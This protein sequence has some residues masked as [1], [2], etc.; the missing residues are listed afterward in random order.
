MTGKKDDA[1]GHDSDSAVSDEL[2]PMR[3]WESG[4]PGTGSY[5]TGPSH[6]D[7]ADF[8]EDEEAEAKEADPK[9]EAE[10]AKPA[11]DE[12]PAEG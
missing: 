3:K 2:A 10:P 6:L 7:R 8:S 12:P 4:K 9:S 5:T 1:C 11:E